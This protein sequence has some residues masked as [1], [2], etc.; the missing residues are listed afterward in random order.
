M[1]GLKDLWLEL[2]HGTPGRRFRDRHGHAHNGLR[3]ALFILAGALL[4]V[5][6]ILL[7]VT[8]GPGMVVIGIGAAIIATESGRVAALL[9]ELELRVRMLL[10]KG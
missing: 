5:V 4:I 2:A 1:R 6:G 3:R 8:P 9:D 7:F 10:K